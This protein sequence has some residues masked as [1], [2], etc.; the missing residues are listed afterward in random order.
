M[1]PNLPLLDIRS[2]CC[3]ISSTYLQVSLLPLL[4]L[5]SSIG[6]STKVRLTSL[7]QHRTQ[8]LEAE[9]NPHLHTVNRI[10]LQTVDCKSSSF[11]SSDRSTSGK[12]EHKEGINRYTGWG[13]CFNWLTSATRF[14]FVWINSNKK[15]FSHLSQA[16]SSSQHIGVLPWPAEKRAT[17]DKCPPPELQMDLKLHASPRG[18][19]L[20]FVLWSKERSRSTTRTRAR[21]E[22]VMGW[23]RSLPNLFRLLLGR[24]TVTADGS[25]QEM[26]GAGGQH[27]SALP[28]LIW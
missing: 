1:Q 14:C 28:A 18:N 19:K 9:K 24:T 11:S 2:E 20:N 23:V 6:R 13:H 25:A 17:W 7:A 15:N 22:W 4:A 26:T 12:E 10:V 8:H 5:C 16:A 3:I 27:Y 21:K